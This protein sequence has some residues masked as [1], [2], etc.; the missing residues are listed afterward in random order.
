[1]ANG[2][3]FWDSSDVLQIPPRHH[4]H[5]KASAGCADSLDPGDSDAID[6]KLTEMSLL[7]PFT[8]IQEPWEFHRLATALLCMDHQKNKGA[9]SLGRRWQRA[10]EDRYSWTFALAEEADDECPLGLNDLK[11]GEQVTMCKACKKNFH[12]ACMN[13]MGN[14]KKPGI[15]PCW[16]VFRTITMI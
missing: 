15:C 7:N 11:I 8:T 12:G 16:Y 10:I 14:L 4:R 2:H 5:C 3:V 9:L 13:E 1:M 6:T